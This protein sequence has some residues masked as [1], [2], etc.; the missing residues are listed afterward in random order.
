M[1][2]LICLL[3]RMIIQN[4]SAQ[5]YKLHKISLEKKET[6]KKKDAMNFMIDYPFKSYIIRR[7]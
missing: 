7:V 5:A 2:K 4:E 6:K 3:T 1:L